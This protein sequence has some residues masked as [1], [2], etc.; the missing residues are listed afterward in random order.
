MTQLNNATTSEK[1]QPDKVIIIQLVA[2][3]IFTYLK[4]YRLIKADLSKQK[5]LDADSRGI[6]QIIITGKLNT[7][8][9]IYYILEQSKEIILQCSKGTTKVLLWLFRNFRI[10]KNES[11]LSEHNQ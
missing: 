7:A 2:Y 10:N 1:Y 8:V 11:K 3:W 5:A 9:I 4:N 6:Q